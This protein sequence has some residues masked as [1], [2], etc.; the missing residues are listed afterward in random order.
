VRYKPELTSILNVMEETKALGVLNTHSG[1]YMGLLYPDS[2]TDLDDLFTSVKNQ[3][4]DFDIKWFQ[5]ITCSSGKEN[6]IYG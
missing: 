1:T 4:P 2:R 3:F 5:T 6:G